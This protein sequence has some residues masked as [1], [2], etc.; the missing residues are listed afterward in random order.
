MAPPGL[1]VGMATD[2]PVSNL[3]EVTRACI[4]SAHGPGSF[5]SMICARRAGA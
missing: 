5:V 1:Q 2:S 4:W 3:R